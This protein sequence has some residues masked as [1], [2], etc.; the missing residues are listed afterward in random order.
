M[1]TR[2]RMHAPFEHRQRRA[3]GL[4]I[5]F[6]QKDGNVHRS[7]TGR[8]IE[9]GGGGGGAGAALRLI[10]LRQV[11]ASGPSRE[12][13]GAPKGDADDEGPQEQEREEEGQKPQAVAAWRRRRLG[14]GGWGHCVPRRLS[15]SLSAR[16]S[17]ANHHRRR[18]S[19]PEYV[20]GVRVGHRLA[21]GRTDMVD[22]SMYVGVGK[23][24]AV[25]VI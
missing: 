14:P 16:S 21:S 17:D 12:Q 13:R 24:D 25:G 5:C 4:G 6:C 15:R 11:G 7:S 22:Q 10:L 8:S 1:H 18:A 19:P 23:V 20:F 3:L 2:A 9:I